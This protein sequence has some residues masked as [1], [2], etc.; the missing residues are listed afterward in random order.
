MPTSVSSFLAV[1][2]VF[3]SCCMIQT[4]GGPLIGIDDAGASIS[5][6]QSGTGLKFLAQFSFFSLHQVF[7]SSMYLPRMQGLCDET[8]D[9]RRIMDASAAVCKFRDDDRSAKNIFRLCSKMT[10]HHRLRTVFKIH[11]NKT[12]RQGL[13]RR[14]HLSVVVHARGKVL[15][16]EKDISATYYSAFSKAPDKG[17]S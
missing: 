14:P 17:R 13:V 15:T 16:K 4:F 9:C 7:C 10:C 6:N 3:D 11:S 5:I 8:C 2:T 12:L 1:P